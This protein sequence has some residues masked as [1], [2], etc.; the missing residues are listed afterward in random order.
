MPAHQELIQLPCFTCA[1]SGIFDPSRLQDALMAK[2]SVHMAPCKTS[3][4]CECKVER[5]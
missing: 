3:C 1:G 4:L 2:K 5:A